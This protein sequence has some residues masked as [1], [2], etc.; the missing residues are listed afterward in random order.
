MDNETLER[1]LAELE[2]DVAE[3]KKAA[4]KPVARDQVDNDWLNTLGGFKDDPIYDEAMRLE[5]AWRRREP[6]C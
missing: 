6:K 5:K 3:L 4:S 1:R 2:K